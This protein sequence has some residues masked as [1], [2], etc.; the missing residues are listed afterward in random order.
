MRISSLWFILP[1]GFYICKEFYMKYTFLSNDFYNDYPN[2]KYPQIE[3]KDKRPYIHMYIDV[4]GNLFCIPLRSNIDHPHA[5]FTN[6]R[7]HCGV[8]Y[9]KAVVITNENYIDTTKKAFL[10]P[11]EHKKLHGKDFLIK[12][13]FMDYIELYKQAKTDKTIPHRENILK[14]STLQYFEEYLDIKKKG[15]AV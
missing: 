14:F 2:E 5:F 11:D 1:E 12:K 7:N 15:T 4:Y 3:Q 9:S 8:D 13:Q 10:R 6:K